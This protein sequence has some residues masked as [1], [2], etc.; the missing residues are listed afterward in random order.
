MKISIIIPVYKV[1]KYLKTCLDSLLEQDL[2]SNDY[3]I[4]C[5]NDGSP[6]NCFQI[7]N[8]YA[9]KYS[10]I[11]AVHQDNR[12][13]SAARNKG[14]ELAQG[15][16][17][18][19]VDADDSLFP[20]VLGTLYTKAKSNALDLLYL[21]VDYF[22]ENNQPIGTFEMESTNE[23]IL[24]GFQHQR[25]GFIFGLYRK[26]ILQSLQFE[27]NIPI[28]EDALF[29]VMVHAKAQ[30]CSYLPVPAY[31]YL[32][33]QGSAINSKLRY[34]DATFAGYLKAIEVLHHFVN[35][36][37]TSY[38]QEQLD[39]FNRPFFKFAQMAL[40]TNVIPNQ[41]PSKYNQLRKK[42]KDKKLKSVE[43]QLKKAFPLYGTSSVVFMGYYKAKRILTQFKNKNHGN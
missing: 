10:N 22:D 15:E 3:E 12:G 19:F 28:A 23:V 18:L 34:A 30:R 21:Q 2:S 31:K 5:I 39:Y 7:L 43:A 8:D 1:E 14:L 20:N 40:D 24:D 29:N 25:R 37:K 42:I 6:D 33:R 32:V 4:I 38:T 13:V 9:Q 26:A 35:E 36:N 16:Y 27:E 11:S 41:S 17:I